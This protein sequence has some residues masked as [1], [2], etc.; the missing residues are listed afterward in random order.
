MSRIWLVALTASFVAACAATGDERSV[1]VE[2]SAHQFG[3]AEMRAEQHCAAYGRKAVHVQ[4][5]PS[6]SGLLGLR[7]AVSVF[8]C[9]AP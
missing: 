3:V 8:E 9:V 1:T 7:T 6:E 4:T 5:G 2:H